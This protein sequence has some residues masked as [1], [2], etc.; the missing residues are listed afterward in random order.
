MLN[1]ALPPVPGEVD[2][3]AERLVQAAACFNAAVGVLR[4]GT[5]TG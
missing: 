1:V 3:D 2:R 5:P 4:L